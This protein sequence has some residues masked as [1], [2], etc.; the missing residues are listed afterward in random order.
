M[1]RKPLRR[2]RSASSTDRP[3]TSFR[4]ELKGLER[5]LMD[6]FDRAEIDRRETNEKIGLVEGRIWKIVWSVGAVALAEV[7]HLV[8]K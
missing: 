2:A 3:S 8:I 4:A 1:A 5:R 6:R 7:L